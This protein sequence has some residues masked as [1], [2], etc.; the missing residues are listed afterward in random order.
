MKKVIVLFSVIQLCLIT[1]SFAQDCGELRIDE[2]NHEWRC[3]DGC[4]R[5]VNTSPVYSDTIVVLCSHDW[6][7]DK[8]RKDKSD[9]PFVYTVNIKCPENTYHYYQ[10]RICSKC[11]QLQTKTREE[12]YYYVKEVSE[13]ERVLNK[14]YPKPDDQ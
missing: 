7:L 2:I 14:Y 4:D 1:Q 3:I 12:R 11:G 13:F 5:H 9:I 8:E 6:I 10:K